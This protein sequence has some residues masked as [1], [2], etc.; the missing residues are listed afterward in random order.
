MRRVQCQVPEKDPKPQ[1][2]G[3]PEPQSLQGL[4]EALLPPCLV[5][6]GAGKGPGVSMPGTGVSFQIES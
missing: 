5:N 4:W 6:A 2:P 1:V 3:L